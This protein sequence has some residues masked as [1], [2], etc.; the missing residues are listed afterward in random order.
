MKGLPE[1]ALPIPNEFSI[2]ETRMDIGSLR[3]L[4]SDLVR[5]KTIFEDCNTPS[6]YH[7]QS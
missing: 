6:F 4:R 1:L 3:D 5:H 2:P 7:P